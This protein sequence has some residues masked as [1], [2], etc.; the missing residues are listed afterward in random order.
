MQTNLF[1]GDTQSQISEY[2][3]FHDPLDSVYNAF[4]SLTLI[5]SVLKNHIKIE[6]VKRNTALDDEGNEITF[7]TINNNSFTFRVENS[8]KAQYHYSFS[9]RCIF[10]PPFL[11]T[12]SINFHFYWDTITEVTVFHGEIAFEDSQYKENMVNLFKQ[13]EIFPI[14]QISEFLKQTVRNL[15]ESESITINDSIDKVWA[16]ISAID[17]L[18]YFFPMKN[19]D[20]QSQNN[21]IIKIIDLTSK[22]EIKLIRK[23]NIN[24][25]RNKM[26]LT[27]ELFDSLI[28]MPK[29][30]IEISS[31][32]IKENSTLVMF[33]H[34]ILEYIPFDALR[35]NSKEKQKI[36]RRIKKKIETNTNNKEQNNNIKS[37]PNIAVVNDLN[38]MLK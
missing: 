20:I 21:Q 35:S 37:N 5:S 28:P 14:K 34:T 12:F 31:V 38:T 33:K 8:R 13:R 24:V 4:T 36:L 17:S 26:E 29:Q 16:F 19:I 15:E 27:L 7:S 32:Q 10:Y 30:L 18:R 11:S 3:I 22:N 2:H 9:L 25:Y 1:A 23:E 6:N